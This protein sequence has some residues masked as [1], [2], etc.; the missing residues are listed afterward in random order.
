MIR[1]EDFVVMKALNQRGIYQK[2]IA[3]ELGVSP[4]TVSRALKRGSATHRERKKRGSQLDAY[5]AR[6]DY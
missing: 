4:K 2:D 5:T 3:E 6:I 1:K